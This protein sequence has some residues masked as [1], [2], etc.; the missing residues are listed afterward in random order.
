MNILVI[1]RTFPWPE[2]NGTAIRVANIVRALSRLGEV[3]FFLLPHWGTPTQTLVPEGEPIARLGRAPRAPRR[4]RA[5]SPRIRQL[6]WL[7]M[8]TL[9]FS[10]DERDYSG[11]R[12][13]FLAWARPR[14]D[15]AWVG[16]AHAYVPL[17]GLIDAPTLVDLDDLED[18]KIGAWMDVASDAKSLADETRS[19]PVAAAIVRSWGS[20]VLNTANR[21]RWR[22]LEHRIASRVEAVV[23]CSELDRERLGVS[24]AV[25]IP[26]GY[27]QPERPAGRVKAGAAILLMGALTY[28]PNADAA[29]FLVKEVLPRVRARLPDARVRLVGH[30]DRRVE[31]LTKLEGVTLTGF[32]PDLAI[33]LARADVVAVPMRFGSGTRV[34][35]LEAFAH[36]LP[37]VSTALGC[38][39]IDI[40]HGRHL[41]VANDAEA[42]ATACA[43]L[44]ADLSLRRKLT[45]E[46]RE[47]YLE[48]YRSDVIASTILDVAR[49]VMGNGRVALARK[50]T[51]LRS[52]LRREN[53]LEATDE[54]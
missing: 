53:D 21:R 11:V 44:L 54:R 27:P 7:A 10:I 17:A 28:A 39:G 19:S 20:R 26:N 46:A 5:R 32:V 30:H 45:A 12:S 15:L 18:R 43:T 48:R 23:V 47:L 33:E 49:D 16:R 41:L 25:V 2:V 8:S 29:R 51:L 6:E 4:G 34:K 37:V 24:N 9:P 31:D 50:E 38:E 3:D 14:Y 52:S 22:G 35:I 1:E 13:A 42:F 36:G 40:V